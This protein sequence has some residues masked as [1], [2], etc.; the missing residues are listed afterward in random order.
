MIKACTCSHK[1]Q[2]QQYGKQ[3]RVHTVSK[4]GKEFRCTVCGPKPRDIQR[5][6]FHALEW[7]PLLGYNP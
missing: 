2:D 1:F 6:F 4:D 5:V 7:K 3:M